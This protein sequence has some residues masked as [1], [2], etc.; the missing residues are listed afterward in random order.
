MERGL[1][2]RAAAAAAATVKAAA[3]AAAAGTTPAAAA[4]EGTAQAAAWQACNVC[5]W[6]PGVSLPC[7]RGEVQGRM[8]P[9][10]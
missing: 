3:S 1:A 2:T 6:L 5:S 4:T 9:N 7:W 8:G 10:R